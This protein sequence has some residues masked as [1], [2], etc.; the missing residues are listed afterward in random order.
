MNRPFDATER[1]S[2]LIRTRPRSTTTWA[3]ALANYWKAYVMAAEAYARRGAPPQ[4]ILSMLEKA[5]TLN[6]RDAGILAFMA[7][8][9]DD[10]GQVEEARRYLELARQVDSSNPLFLRVQQVLQRKYG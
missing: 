4:Q 7:A 5:L 2:R 8:C 3:R 6:P 1:F 9:F 10:L